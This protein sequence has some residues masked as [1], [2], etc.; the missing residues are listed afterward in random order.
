[1]KLTK[2]KKYI[3]EEIQRLYEN[4]YNSIYLKKD[5]YDWEVV[6]GDKITKMSDEIKDFFT[7]FILYFED[8]DDFFE[9]NTTF[10][11]EDFNE[12]HYNRKKAENN[13]KKINVFIKLLKQ[14]SEKIITDKNALI[15]FKSFKKYYL[16]QF[17]QYFTKWK[18]YDKKY[19][20]LLNKIK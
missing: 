8:I 19:K 11:K 15:Y 20:Q 14:K 18:K 10:N 3:K 5:G 16:P 12:L 13:I 6:L 7:N 2:L 1:M 9:D 17:K 4:K